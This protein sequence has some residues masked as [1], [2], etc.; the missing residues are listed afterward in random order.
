[1]ADFPPRFERS[2]AKAL[3]CV[4]LIY[5]IATRFGCMPSPIIKQRVA[6]YL[7]EQNPNTLDQLFARDIQEL[8]KAGIPYSVER[9]TIEISGARGQQ[10]LE[11]NCYRLMRNELYYPIDIGSA[12]RSVRAAPATEAFDTEDL[13][14]LTDTASAL[15][16]TPPRCTD[17][18]AALRVLNLETGLRTPTLELSAQLAVT[19]EYLIDLIAAV[20]FFAQWRTSASDGTTPEEIGKSLGLSNEVVQLILIRAK[21]L[22]EGVSTLGQRAFRILGLEDAPVIMVAPAVDRPWRVRRR[23]IDALIQVADGAGISV[24]EAFARRL[25]QRSRPTTTSPVQRS[26]LRAPKRANAG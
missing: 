14:A 16:K 13:G 24:T 25:Y 1:M 15:E 6:A 18:L 19:T 7:R 3:R 4:E 22:P 26:V 17:A 2:L 11:V 8:T 21:Q 12:A 5:C 9:R 23:Y 20:F 10:E